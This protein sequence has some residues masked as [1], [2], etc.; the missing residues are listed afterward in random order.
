MKKLAKPEATFVIIAVFAWIIVFLTAKLFSS[1]LGG[2]TGDTYGA[3]I[4]ITEVFVLISI[5]IIGKAGG[6]S[7]LDS[8]L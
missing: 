1:R 6:T 4:E 5:I 3:I 8:Y 7:W 2:L